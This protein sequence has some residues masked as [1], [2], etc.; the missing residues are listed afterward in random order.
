VQAVA[1]GHAPPATPMPEHVDAAGAY[2][3]RCTH[4]LAKDGTTSDDGL[5]DWTCAPGLA[6]RAS[7]VAGDPV[8]SCGTAA[9]PYKT[10]DACERVETAPETPDTHDGDLVKPLHPER[11]DRRDGGRCHPNEDG[12]P[13]GMCTSPC[14]VEGEEKDGAIC[15][16][17]PHKGF[18]KACFKE[19]V[20]LEKCLQAPGNF[21]IERMKSC[22]RTEACRDDFVCTR[23]PGI[24][25][26]K[27]AC[28]PP[29][30]LFEARVD[31][32]PVDR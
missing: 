31:G 28:V 7:D 21:A 20:T 14:T 32:P 23:V 11:C 22:S 10:G 8:G 3:A 13:G 25:G 15:M 5:P 19:G 6:C 30:F 9:I 24:P 17:I 4:A 18:E 26:D 12:F 29:Y 16:R 1:A 2:G 27:G